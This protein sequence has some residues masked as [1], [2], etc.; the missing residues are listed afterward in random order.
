MEEILLYGG[1][2]K[3]NMNRS[4]KRFIRK[5]YFLK[6]HIK[7]IHDSRNAKEENFDTMQQEDEKVRKSIN[8]L[9][10]KEQHIKVNEYLKF[11]EV[12]DRKRDS[13]VGQK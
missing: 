6:D 7:I 4:K 9:N 1:E 2:I 5:N 10:I 13:F 3:C 12:Q 11:V 8:P